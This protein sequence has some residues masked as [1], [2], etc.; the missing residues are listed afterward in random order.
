[1]LTIEHLRNICVNQCP[2]D[3]ADYRRFFLRISAQSAGDNENFIL[4][5]KGN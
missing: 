3:C 1:M 5:T 2:A 4:Q